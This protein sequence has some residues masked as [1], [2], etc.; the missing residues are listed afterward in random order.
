MTASMKKETQDCGS[1]DVDGMMT[2]IVS[3]TGYRNKWHL[4]IF[5]GIIIVSLQDGGNIMWPVFGAAHIPHKCRIPGLDHP[6]FR[7]V[8]PNLIETTF[9]DDPGKF[10]CKGVTADNQNGC[11]ALNLDPKELI[12]E[13]SLRNISLSQLLSAGPHQ[14]EAIGKAEFKRCDEMNGYEFMPVDVEDSVASEMELLCGRE[15]YR[16]IDKSF[17][18]LGQCIGAILLGYLSDRFGRK[19]VLTIQFILEIPFIV[20]MSFC[21]HMPPI[22]LLRFIISIFNMAKYPIAITVG[23]EA[24]LPKHRN[25]IGI[26]PGMIYGIGASVYTVFAYFIR[27]WRIFTTTGMWFCIPCMLYWLLLMPESP[28]WLLE[29]GRYREFKKVAKDIE[30]KSKKPINNQLWNKLDKFIAQEPERMSSWES[31]KNLLRC[32]RSLNS[33]RGEASEKQKTKNAHGDAGRVVEKSSGFDKLAQ[34]FKHPL[35]RRWLMIHCCIWSA[36]MVLYYTLTMGQDMFGLDLYTFTFMM[37]FFEIPGVLLAISVVNFI[38]RRTTMISGM[39][40]CAFFLALCY[41]FEDEKV[42]LLISASFSKLFVTGTFSLLFLYSGES[43]PTLSRTTGMGFCSAICR[44]V[45]SAFPFV[46]MLNVYIAGASLIFMIGLSILSAF[47][48]LFLPETMGQELP[49]T[50]KD[51]E[52]LARGQ[53]KKKTVISSGEI[54]LGVAQ[55]RTVDV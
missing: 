48:C 20:G 31:V 42:V 13:A 35:L 39:L 3:T 55:C 41:F 18:A 33:Q 34:L 10:G 11:T 16:R 26:G 17:F 49:D 51:C 43:L 5:T 23:A 21:N 28:R 25:I 4:I 1:G 46:D 45:G 15:Y 54:E 27:T 47:L 14:S 53:L 40:L 22:I 36:N 29:V 30:K 19:R 38:G 44:I 2:D 24:V 50:V 7:D 8:P 6:A 52:L 12:D 9:Y 32:S 37:G